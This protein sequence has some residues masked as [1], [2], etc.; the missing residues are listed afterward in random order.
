M[1]G[2]AQILFDVAISDQDLK[3]ILL[4]QQNNLP[5]HLTEE[6]RKSQ[7]FVTVQHNLPLLRS[8]NTSAPQVLA[9]HDDKV[10]GYALSMRPE[11]KYVVPVLVPMFELVDGLY[12]KG[13]LL[14]KS[15]YYVMGQICVDEAYRG[16]GIF[17]GL[18]QKHRQIY[19]SQYDLCITEVSTRNLRSMK[20]HQRVGFKTIHTFRDATDEWNIVLWDWIKG[21]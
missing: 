12:Y 9:R 7:G 14:S 2:L 15:K 3:Q 19:S 1:E 20:A 18:Y 11:L 21:A 6:R 8:M 4:L 16:E 5:D 13:E 10:I 17:D